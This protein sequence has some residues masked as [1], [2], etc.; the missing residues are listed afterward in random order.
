MCLF[1]FSIT[2]HLWQF[3]G[4]PVFELS[5]WGL[6]V[7]TVSMKACHES[8]SGFHLRPPSLRRPS[9]P[10]SSSSPIPLYHSSA[11]PWQ[12]PAA[13]H[14]SRQ[15]VTTFVVAS[16]PDVMVVVVSC[17]SWS[18][19][20]HLTKIYECRE[21]RETSFWSTGCWCELENLL[22]QVR[23]RVGAGGA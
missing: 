7:T 13:K 20:W 6:S 19:G 12:V 5:A 9:S 15:S 2:S 4:G 14:F 23:R 10:S 18:L 8:L 3:G 22:E 16:P 11:P 17:P 1:V 21:F